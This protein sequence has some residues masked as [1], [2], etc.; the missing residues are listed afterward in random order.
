MKRKIIAF[1]LAILIIGTACGR[2]NENEVSFNSEDET[3]VSPLSEILQ[4]SVSD[5][6]ISESAEYTESQI[7]EAVCNDIYG[8]IPESYEYENH[9]D[10]LMKTAETITERFLGEITSE[11]DL[12]EKS[13]TVFIEK[14][15][16]IALIES[17]YVEVN[18]IKIKYERDK[19]P[20]NVKYY[21]KYDTWY[22]SPNPPS[23]TREDGV[24]IGAPAMSMYMI[25]RGS[26]GMIM[27]ALI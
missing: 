3:A 4:N 18:G 10:Y 21:E 12:I 1:E 13:R 20:Y 22:I 6:V 5:N 8:Y 11:E 25:I 17:D 19:P 26:D 24:K 15:V 16:D 14:G 7:V 2:L 27:G 23:G 9:A